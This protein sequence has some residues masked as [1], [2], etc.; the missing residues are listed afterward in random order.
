M[1]KNVY[2]CDFPEV[3]A[4]LKNTTYIQ[5]ATALAVWYKNNADKY[6]DDDYIAEVR[7][8]TRENAIVSFCDKVADCLSMF[9]ERAYTERVKM[10]TDAQ[11]KYFSPDKA[12]KLSS[13]N[14]SETNATLDSTTETTFGGVNATTGRLSDKTKTSGSPTTKT[15]T[16]TAANDGRKNSELYNDYTTLYSPE[17]YAVDLLK[18]FFFFSGGCY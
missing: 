18:S 10:W 12:G 8:D 9:G 1:A 15:T 6:I 4:V 3:W 16:K 2:F 5:G 14:E 7:G 11:D 13:E 17:K